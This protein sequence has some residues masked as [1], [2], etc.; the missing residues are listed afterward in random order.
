MLQKFEED[1][2]MQTEDNT[3]VENDPEV[4]NLSE[5]SKQYLLSVAKTAIE[6]H[7]NG[8]RPQ[9]LIYDDPKLKKRW[10]AFVTIK[11]GKNLRGCIGNIMSDRPIPETVA[12]MAV[13]SASMDPR[14]PPIG[15]AELEKLHV[16]ISILGPLTEVKEINE[17]VI[18]R[19][20]LVV[21]KMGRHGLLLPQVAT[22]YN[23]D[24]HQFIQE[25]C[26]KAG[27]PPDAYEH[28][29]R[30]FKFAAEVF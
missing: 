20:G 21:E 9:R 30:L 2:P 28:G 18:G 7:V 29:A 27:L 12:D 25:T 3:P 8:E 15:P 6:R 19:H 23:L 26:V 14:F 24:V 5:E 22:E 17:I 1:A 4:P 10:G 13:K 11:I 16:D